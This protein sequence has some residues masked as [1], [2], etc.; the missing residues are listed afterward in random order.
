MVLK[1]L[2][3]ISL[4]ILGYLFFWPTVVDPQ[5][6]QVIENPGF[7]GVYSMNSLLTDAKAFDIKGVGPEDVAP[8]KDW[9][10][11]GLRDG[12][13]IRYRPSDGLQ[14]DFAHTQGRPLGLAWDESG[15]LIVADAYKGLLRIRD[16]EQIEVLATESDGV[17]FGFTDDVD[18][19]SDGR[20][21]FT[22]AS[23]KYSQPD[24]ILDALEHRP[25]GRLLVYDPKSGEVTTL[26]SDL[27]FP[28]G[29][30]VEEDAEF[31][32]F[33]ETWK[34]RVSKFWL[35][36]PKKGQSEVVL[37][38]L[39]GFPDGISR[40]SGGTYWLA[41]PSPRNPIIDSLAS[42][43]ALR[44]VVSRLPES[45][46]PGAKPYG[47]VFGIGADGQVKYN[48]QDPEGN[49]VQMITSVEEYGG[50]LFL[51]SLTEARFGKYSPKINMGFISIGNQEGSETRGF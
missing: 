32:L 45:L 6:W 42:L 4:S 18:V 28:N 21:Y 11:M 49:T 23:S 51:G 29:V 1:S 39:P 12:R 48:F 30:A 10:Y 34:Y 24:Y 22:D 25:N 14:E 46:W 17:P 5:S 15:S 16:R 36:G 43:P 44:K 40:G 7:S 50:K 19:G 47:G 37:D 27:Y 13:I 9:V 33:N 38:N 35:A 8:N 26:L 41:I 3:L 2:L 20:I 31:L